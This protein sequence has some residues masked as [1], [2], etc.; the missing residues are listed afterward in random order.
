MVTDAQRL[1]ARGE[2]DSAALAVGIAAEYAWRCPFGRLASPPL[3]GILYGLA[4]R[5]LPAAR[6]TPPP[7]DSVLHVATKALGVGGLSGLLCRWIETDS[8]RTHDVVL[9]GQEGQRLATRLLPAIRSSGGTLHDLTGM[10][11]TD[12]VRTLRTLASAHRYC[13]VHQ[14]PSD[15]VVGLALMIEPRSWST[16]VVDH[17]DHVFWLGARMADVVAHTRPAAVA[18]AATHRGLPE[19]TA[20]IIPIP[21]DR[22]DVNVDR[23]SARARL[24]LT[25]DQILIASVASEYKYGNATSRHFLDAIEPLLMR[26]AGLNV[27]AVGPRLSGRWRAAAAR[28]PGR[29]QAVGPRRDLGT[30]LA[31]ADI[32]IDSYPLPSFTAVIHAAQMGLPTVCRRFPH[33]DLAYLEL[34]DERV[35]T[36]VNWAQSDAEVTEIVGS[37]VENLPARRRSGAAAAATMLRMSERDDWLR[38]L[39]RAYLQAETRAAGVV[40]R[41]CR[42][43][44]MPA[45]LTEAVADAHH[46]GGLDA[47]FLNVVLRRHHA[48][49]A[50]VDARG[51]ARALWRVR[52]DRM[53]RRAWGS[54]VASR[55]AASLGTRGPRSS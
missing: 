15:V 45:L 29:V 55:V 54:L 2:D 50:P 12:R 9:T 8:A 27:I 37:W 13:V 39:E 42:V 19:S 40:E 20:T 32:Y 44:K 34:D 18:I 6:L 48:F 14:D 33:P 23:A 46:G 30:F 52:G 22:A 17:A 31:A 47:A 3:E 25:S 28:F 51:R 49:E 21:L 35:V 38:T 11:L 53:T 4:Q 36:A 5:V 10:R 1:F 41:A 16:I 26:Y 43:T 7:S 24:G